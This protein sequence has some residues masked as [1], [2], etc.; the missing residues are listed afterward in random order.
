MITVKDLQQ[1]CSTDSNRDYIRQP[2]SRGTYTYAT[3]GHVLIRVP[4]FEMVAETK[5]A[6][7]VNKIISM[8][9]DQTEVVVV[10]CSAAEIPRGEISECDE[11]AG[12]GV[13]HDCPECACQCDECGGTGEEEERTSVGIFG[14]P[15]DAKYIRLLFALPGFK[16]SAA[17]PPES[18]ARFVFDDGEGVIMPLRH[19]CAKHTVII[20]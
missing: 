4:R 17:P 1:F 20:P 2:W 18:G 8:A 6:P 5:K 3:N 15:Y 14:V 16:F 10:P 11:C 7:G 13:L 9:A 19:P 12:R